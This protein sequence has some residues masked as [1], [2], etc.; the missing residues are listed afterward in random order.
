MTDNQKKE[1]QILLTE[2]I[3]QYE[4]QAKAVKALKNVSEG[5]I[6]NIRKGNW[7]S[8]S[9]QMW[10]NIGKQVGYSTKGRWKT[11][12]TKSFNALVNLF[13]DAKEYSNVYCVIAPA[14]SGKN[15]ACEW[16][17]KNRINAFHVECAEYFNRKVFL[18]QIL[19]KMGKSESTG[20]A[21]EMMEAIV[22]HLLRMED[23]VLFINEADKLNDSNLYFFI[24]LYNKLKGKCGIV[25]LATEFL[26]KRID[27]GKRLN[28]KGYTE[29]YSRIGRR[30]ITIPTTTKEEVATI[31][32]SNGVDDP[33]AITT[34]YN[35][36]EGDLRRVE[37]AVHKFKKRQ[38]K[39]S[40]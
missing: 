33:I 35:E 13:D 6:I 14:G 7:E 3:E 32:K 16:Y 12:K 22:E 26:K 19:E 39:A 27:R 17:E 11:V 18:A 8:I 36:Y 2:F 4:S 21:Y 24:T 28:R 20:T 23:P 38:S 30:F 15:W 31:C 1:I 37:R 25:L 9:D 40:A 34:I 10:T 29:I 5:V